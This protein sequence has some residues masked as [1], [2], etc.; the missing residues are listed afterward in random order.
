MILGE[1]DMKRI[2]CLFLTVCLIFCTLTS[3]SSCQTR[4]KGT[5]TSGGGYDYSG[6]GSSLGMGA[7]TT[8]YVFEGKR[9]SRTVSLVSGINT[10]Q[11]T[12]TYDIDYKGAKIG[13]EITF[14]WDATG[15]YAGKPEE[16]RTETHR[17]K[18]T[19]TYIK[20]DDEKYTKSTN[21][22]L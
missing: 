21:N 11:V 17:F 4:L 12:G 2:F 19:N 3:L 15:D 7:M 9:V 5:Y 16:A 18:K 6:L 20:I 22:G 8:T 1:N 13:Y 14:V 10:P